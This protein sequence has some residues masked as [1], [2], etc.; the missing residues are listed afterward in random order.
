MK[1]SPQDREDRSNTEMDSPARLDLSPTMAEIR[2]RFL[3]ADRPVTA[4]ALAEEILKRHRDDLGGRAAA[5]LPLEETATERPVDEWLREIAWLFDPARIQELSPSDQTPALHGRLAIIGLCL[6][7]PRLRTQ[8]ER[9]DLFQGLIGE[10]GEPIEEILTEQ[11]RFAFRAS[12]AEMDDSVP[13][14]PDDPLRRMEEDQLGR[15]AFAR[16]LARR[17]TAV[18]EEA[19]AYAIHV[20]GP[21]GSGKT[22]LRNFL[23]RELEDAYG[24]NV[25]DF[26]AWR[27]QHVRPPWWSLLESVFQ[28]AKPH[29]S[30]W[31]RWR[32][33]WWRFNT[34]RIHYVFGAIV[35]VWVV[36][37]IV[38]PIFRE[39]A[40]DTGSLSFW[41]GV[42]DEISKILAVIL[43][44]WGIVYGVS[45]S[46]LLNSAKAAQSYM[47]LTHD[48]MNMIKK[49]F[50]GLVRRL[51]GQRMAI[52]IDDLD[53]CQSGYVIELLEGMQTLFREAPVVFVVTADRR[54]LNA[55]YEET[56]EKLK[57]FVSEP[58][59]PLGVLFLEKAF[60]F[61]TPV[62]GIPREMKE[63]FWKRLI[64]VKKAAPESSLDAAR[65][66]A[67]GVMREAETESAVRSEVDESRE[68]PFH[69][70]RAI[71]EEAVIRLAAPEILARLEHTLTPYVGLLE[72]NPR[73]MKRLV[74][75]Y[76]A[77]RALA[78]LS[79][80]DI[81][82][83]QLVLWTILSS[84]WPQLADYLAKH[85]EMVEKI[86]NKDAHEIRGGLAQLVGDAAVLH[87]LQGGTTDAAL[88][89]KTI[90][91]CARMHV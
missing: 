55:C 73:S 89:P 32:E 64:L 71:R 3:K 27:N 59:K 37:L 78:I 76:S 28:S 22:T 38:F 80:V 8:L 45:R 61:A 84:R 16:F 12:D 47:E 19:G 66:K 54:W 77:N 44:I 40:G 6:L 83:H 26:N 41:A 18:P 7:E 13:T 70:Q 23:R 11:G 35:L 48:P 88:L 39:T 82:T 2:D 36:A 15:S 46:F 85:P 51:R 60:Q 65:E 53:R 81:D 72:P 42:A 43:T 21:W 79:E 56:Y 49:R 68:L 33:Y 30:P 9:A 90:R 62:P 4:A 24:W 75:T 50:Q 5:A 69:E 87:V 17:I 25:T 52:F 20:Y 74:N 1:A 67:S 10:L 86:I 91:D 63:A 58:G 14:Q 29:L 34:G 57:P 31:N